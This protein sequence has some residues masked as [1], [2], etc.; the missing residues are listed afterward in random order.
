MRRLRYL[1][2]HL[3]TLLPTLAALAQAPSATR[4]LPQQ[5]ER[6][7]SPG[8][9]DS[10]TATADLDVGGVRATLSNKGG[11]LDSIGHVYEVPK[12]SGVGL[13]LTMGAWLGG[14]VD[15]EPRFTGTFYNDGEWGPGPL[16]AS[17]APPADC[18]SAFDRIWL[19]TQQPDGSLTGDV[20]DWPAELG[21]PFDDTDGDGVYEPE[22]G[23]TPTLYGHQTA[24][25]VMNDLTVP[26]SPTTAEPLGVTARVTAFAFNSTD[27]A[28]GFGTFYRYTFENPND[29]TV[30][31][32]RFGL[33]TDPDLGNFNDDFFGSD[34]GRG[35]SFAYNG[36]SYDEGEGF[37][38][39][40][41]QPP[42]MGIDILSG[43]AGFF[44]PSA[45]MFFS[46]IWGSRAYHALNFLW[47]D[48]TPLTLGGSGYNP[49]Q[50]TAPTTTWHWSGA[51]E[52]FDFWSELNLDASGAASRLSD[53]LEGVTV[54]T[55]FTLPPGATHT[56]DIAMLWGRGVSFLDSVTQ[57][58]AH[59]DR[60]QASYDSGALFGPAAPQDGT[61]DGTAPPPPLPTLATPI[62]SFP[63]DEADLARLALPDPDPDCVA[64]R[65]LVACTTVTLSWEPVPGATYYEV[66][67]SDT[68]DFSGSPILFTR[69][70]TLESVALTSAEPSRIYWRVR[71]N[72]TTELSAFSPARFYTT[73]FEYVPA[74]RDVGIVEVAYGGTPTCAP[75]DSRLDCELAGGVNV[76]LRPNPTNDYYVTSW[77]QGRLDRIEWRIDIAAP[78]DYEMRFTEA[79]AA[80]DCYGINYLL[81]GN[82][83]VVSVPFEL[84]QT[85]IDTPD[86]P[87]DDVQLIPVLLRPVDG[88]TIER[89][90]YAVATNP[91]NGDDVEDTNADFDALASDAI[92]WM[93]PDRP[94]G[95]AR[96]AEAAATVGIGN[97]LDGFDTQIDLDPSTGEPC[98]RQGFFVEFC[99]RN[100][101]LPDGADNTDFISLISRFQL[102]D[103]AGDGTP[104]PA[105]TVLRVLTTKQPPPV[106]EEE[107]PPSIP[108]SATLAV[109]P[110]PSQGLVTVEYGQASRDAAT[111]EVFDTVGRLVTRLDEGTQ[112]AGTY[113]VPLDLSDYAAGLYFVV[114]RSADTNR[115]FPI[116]VFR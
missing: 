12:N 71:S 15:G 46:V 34:P 81:Q 111:I 28:L 45:G 16:D 68:D 22:A 102:A 3:A 19:V 61:P 67:I 114:F 108:Q 87:T 13:F 112:D 55:P 99:H 101:E 95:H 113:A 65:S 17:G 110:N 8:D 54:A 35:L 103:Q 85:G 98:E 106:S 39:Y 33:F 80:G 74:I 92:Y 76:W 100:D 73:R 59:S 83:E 1:S 64:D 57:L 69:T 32:A 79:C 90:R 62:P 56:V 70:P 115:V 9:C 49:D 29:Y 37:P 4:V 84:W 89:W 116:S 105:G 20:D 43:A 5:A 94:D 14:T 41:A 78:F 88:P 58:R 72:T 97:V 109:F 36:D 51:P 82:G 53:R 6:V 93:Y 44:S 104:P 24:F 48:S 31:N 40:R 11:F 30:E 63:D 7:V 107:P 47:E 18:G 25:W 50:S 60:V 23:E 10:G 2:L 77:R 38:T 26:N 42:A 86:D 75:D 91:G 27:P 66:Q 52:T 96:F 21:A